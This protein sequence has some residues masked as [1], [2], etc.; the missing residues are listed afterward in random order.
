MC[1]ESSRCCL[2][3]VRLDYR[4]LSGSRVEM[5]FPGLLERSL[6]HAEDCLGKS[7]MKVF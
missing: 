6:G 4:G 7:T 2:G 5:C 3:L 1:C